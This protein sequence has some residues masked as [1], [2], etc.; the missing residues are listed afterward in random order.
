[1]GD[2]TV[3]ASMR[4]DASKFKEE[5]KSALDRFSDV[6]KHDNDVPTNNERQHAVHALEVGCEDVQT[7]L[8]RLEH[9][10]HLYTACSDVCRGPFVV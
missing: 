3:P 6:G 7:P 5:A 2:V 1:M 9:T 10:L 8:T 4:I